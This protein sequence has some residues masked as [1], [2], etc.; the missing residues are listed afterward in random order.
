MI[1][2]CV[3]W[4][5]KTRNIADGTRCK[6]EK[7]DGR[8]GA[9]LRREKLKNMGKG[10]R[11]AFAEEHGSA[12]IGSFFKLRPSRPGAGKKKKNG[13]GGLVLGG[14]GVCGG[15]L[16]GF[17]GGGGGGA[18]GKRTRREAKSLDRGGS[19]ISPTPFEVLACGAREG[20]KL[21]IFE[22]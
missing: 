12:G 13:G 22:Y 17:G 7:K 4:R 8:P 14:G 6:K 10:A 18:E 9:D 3:L 21:E 11:P 5:G 20:T 15:W 1:L 19:R 2:S 16:V